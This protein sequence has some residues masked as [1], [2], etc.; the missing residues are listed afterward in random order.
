MLVSCEILQILNPLSLPLNE[1]KLKHISWSISATKG[2]SDR[3]TKASDEEEEGNGKAKASRTSNISTIAFPFLTWIF[4]DWHH[5]NPSTTVITGKAHGERKTLRRSPSPT[6]QNWNS[7][8]GLPLPGPR[9]PKWLLPFI[10]NPE[11]ASFD[12]ESRTIFFTGCSLYLQ[13]GATF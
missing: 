3:V 5:A 12:H 4:T 7:S 8:I 2:K 1:A 6:V 9:W 11:E 13:S 10:S